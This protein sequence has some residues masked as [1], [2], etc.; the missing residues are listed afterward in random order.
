MRNTPSY[1]KG[2]AET[3]ARAARDI[4]CYQHDLSVKM[5]SGSSSAGRGSLSKTSGKWYWELTHNPSSTATAPVWGL[6]SE[7]ATPSGNWVGYISS[8]WVDYFMTNGQPF[9][10]FAYCG[11]AWGAPLA[12]GQTWGVASTDTIGFALDMD[13]HTLNWYKNGQLIGALCSNLPVS[14][15]PFVTY[16]NGTSVTSQVDANFGQAE[17]KYPVPAGYNAGLW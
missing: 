11:N 2:L 17:F 7:S 10:G 9:S 8:L 12:T 14:V 4:Q 6:I 5:T 16:G 15:R 1:L 3:R 13:A